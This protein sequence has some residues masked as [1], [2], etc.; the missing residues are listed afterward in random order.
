MELKQHISY[1]PG[2]LGFTVYDV[3]KPHRI[4]AFYHLDATDYLSYLV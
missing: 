3:Q 2:T 4:H 1:D